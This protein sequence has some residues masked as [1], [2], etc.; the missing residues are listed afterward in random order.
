MLPGRASRRST[1][2]HA[3]DAGKTSG[4]DYRPPPTDGLRYR[5]LLPSTSFVRNNCKFSRLMEMVIKPLA[6]CSPPGFGN[7]GAV[8]LTAHKA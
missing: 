1:A 3:N 5:H 4:R 2:M 7:Q 8:I 6:A